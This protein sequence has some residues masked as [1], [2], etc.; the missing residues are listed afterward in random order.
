MIIKISFC[1]ILLSTVAYGQNETCDRVLDSMIDSCKAIR[2][3]LISLDSLDPKVACCKNA[4]YDLCVQGVKAYITVARST[5]I[6]QESH[7][8]EKLNGLESNIAMQA[9][10]K[11]CE[12]FDSKTCIT[13]TV[14]N[15]WNS[16]SETLNP[17]NLSETI[18]KNFNGAMSSIGNFMKNFGNQAQNVGSDASS[19]LS[20]LFTQQQSNNEY[21][22][23]TPDQQQQQP[24]PSSSSINSLTN[25]ISKFFQQITQPVDIVNKQDEK[26]DGRR[27]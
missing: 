3:T 22:I 24:L 19:K 17:T 10:K 23:A 20:E 9:V 15:A 27:R 1:L 8:E 6:C 25:S 14:S 12:N 21:S 13:D 16:I 7:Y 2:T 4:R 11:L 5:R 18:S 26:K